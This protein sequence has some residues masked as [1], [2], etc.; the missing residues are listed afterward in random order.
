LLI[1]GQLNLHHGLGVCYTLIE[2]K[3]METKEDIKIKEILEKEEPLQKKKKQVEPQFGLGQV[4]NYGKSRSGREYGGFIRESVRK[5]ME[6]KPTNRGRSI[7]KKG[8]YDI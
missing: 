3:V 5:K 6:F 2:K 4:P 1:I 8:P 7:N